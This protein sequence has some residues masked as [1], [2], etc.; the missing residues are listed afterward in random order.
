M[1]LKK[2]TGI[3]FSFILLIVSAMAQAGDGVKLPQTAAAQRMSAFVSAFNSGEANA[4]RDFHL[5]NDA[6]GVLA[7]GVERM[8][9][10]DKQMQQDFGALTV[11]KVLDSSEHSIT[12]VLRAKNGQWIKMRLEVDPQAPN[13]IIGIGIEPT[14]AVE[15]KK[16]GEAAAQAS[17]RGAAAGDP[18]LDARTREEVIDGA[19]RNLN[20]AYV[21]PDVAKQMEKALRDR[22]Q[23]KEYDNV[24][25]P[26]AFAEMLTNHLREVSHD[27]HLRVIYSSDVIPVEDPQAEPSPEEQQRF[28]NYMKAQNWGFEKVERLEGNIGYLDLRGFFDADSG[29]DT[30]AAAMNFL[31][32][33]DALI[34]DLRKN[35]GGSPAMVALISTYLFEG[36]QVHLNDIYWR[37]DNSTRQWWTLPYVPG[38]RYGKKDVYVLTSSSTFS[39]AEEFTYNLKNL[40]RATIVGETTGGGAHPGGPRRINDHFMVGVPSGRAINPITKT[41][42]EGT[43]IKPDVET[44]A[45]RALKTAHLLAL[46]KTMEAKS[47]PEQKARLRQTIASLE[48]ETADQKSSQ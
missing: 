28:R 16:P 18:A 40:K 27:K 4:M 12:A 11:R 22:A 46:K 31:A 38:Q 1:K 36:R 47:D 2:I 39:A 17:G 32:N 3:S 33:T 6:A 14:D 15:E 5:N 21:F 19:I 24:T 34:I 7:G 48:K 10:Q 20:D 44:S 8:L 13:K 29:G 35:G 23:N 37:P 25:S 26:R 41:N 42:W 45:A 9:D 43:G 30:V